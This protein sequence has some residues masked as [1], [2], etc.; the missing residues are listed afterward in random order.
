MTAQQLVLILY[1]VCELLSFRYTKKLFNE[2]TVKVWNSLPQLI[3]SIFFSLASS[4][5]S[6]LNKI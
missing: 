3:L 2:R 4:F 1:I 5:K 6:S